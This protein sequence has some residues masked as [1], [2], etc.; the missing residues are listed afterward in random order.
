MDY[1]CGSE[2]AFKEVRNV[3]ESKQQSFLQSVGE[4]CKAS[5]GTVSYSN[6]RESAK[7]CEQDDKRVEVIAVA[8]GKDCKVVAEREDSGKSQP[9]TMAQSQISSE[10]IVHFV[11]GS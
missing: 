5:I 6:T 4:H 10:K 8:A 3:E 11:F 7:L 2:K 1:N 9:L